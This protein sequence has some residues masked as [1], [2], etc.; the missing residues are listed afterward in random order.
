MWRLGCL[1]AGLPLGALAAFAFRPEP[2]PLA[3]EVGALAGA[4]VLLG[5]ASL[6]ERLYRGEPER[7]R[8]LAAAASV[9]WLALPALGASWLGLLPGPR[10]WLVGIGV[11]LVL[12]LWRGAQRQGPVSLPASAVAAPGLA[13]LAGSLV[14]AVLGGALAALGAPGP[15]ASE[16]SAN[17]VWDLDARIATEPPPR[18]APRAAGHSVLLERGAHPRLAAGGRLLWFEAAGPD[19]RRQVH[20]LERSSG[21]VTCWTCHEAGNNRRPAPSLSGFGLVFDTDRHATGRD[22]TNT[23]IHLASTTGDASLGV[24]RRLTFARGPDDH[25][26]MDP[27][28]R[29]LV[30]SR[31]HEGR[32]AVV[33]AVVQSGHGGLLLGQPRVLA[34]GGA[35][36]VAP[37][38]WSPDA[39]ALVV[40]RGH[41]GRPATARAIDFATDREWGL[42][43]G[44]VPAGAVG[45]NADGSW[46]ALAAT[47]R[48]SALGLVPASLGF[49]V[50]RVVTAA[51]LEGP[52]FRGSEVRTGESAG[53]PGRVDLGGLADWG[54][55]T[56][57]ALEPDG[58]GFVLGQR[59][60]GPA[61][62]EERLVEV[63]LACEE[64]ALG[65]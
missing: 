20:R 14:A 51:G 16:R 60:R 9:G 17:Y 19:G 62:V 38:G 47:R 40:A 5:A 45:F 29:L 44:V 15:E 57:I 12:A 50:G 23:E 24:S 35:S 18:C 11:L 61:G 13:L 25:A 52:W 41:P 54:E 33:S 36:W 46:L 32:Y 63:A 42:G 34:A 26:I 6:A 64:D 2:W 22:P 31:G 56:G 49:L 59:R 4:V 39:H 53:E 1:L 7:G 43:G 65:S 55:S 28:G 30:W 58:R 37:L 48:E 8:H 3:L 21:E 27:G 10:V